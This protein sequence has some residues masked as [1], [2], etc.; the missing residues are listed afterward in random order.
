MTSDPNVK[1]I[2]LINPNSSKSMTEGLDTLLSTLNP[3]PSVHVQTYTA[4]PPSPESINNETDA[5]LSTKVV[6]SDLESSLGS[7][8][9]FLIACYSVHP[10]V[11]AIRE[12]VKPDVY[13]MGIFEASVMMALGLLPQGNGRRLKTGGGKKEGFGIVST[14]KYWEEVLGEGVRQFLGVDDGVNC[15]RFKGVETTGLNAGELHSVEPEIVRK[16]MKDAVKRLVGGRD[17]SAICL[18][19]AGMAGM[20]EMV[21]EALDE[22][23]GKED[24]E[25][26]YIVDG[27]KAGVVYLE[28]LLKAMPDRKKQ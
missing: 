23:L 5:E 12:R 27:V 4:P 10:L 2:L 3:Q 9:A 19:C 7:Y 26:V 20:D 6:L 15:D 21:R 14:G 11:S 1:T 28:G 8:D 18:G 25:N 17:C 22:E 24:S 13:V 16:K